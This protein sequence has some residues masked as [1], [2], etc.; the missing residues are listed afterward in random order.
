MRFP[1]KAGNALPTA[2]TL[3]FRLFFAWAVLRSVMLLHPACVSPKTGD[4]T[5]WQSS[6]FI[7]FAW[8]C[9]AVSIPPLCRRTSALH[10]LTAGIALLGTA[11]AAFSIFALYAPAGIYDMFTSGS[12]ATG[13][14][15]SGNSL[16]GFLALCLP[17]TLTLAQLAFI[18]ASLHMRERGWQLLHN[19]RPGDFKLL[20]AVLW[21]FAALLQSIALI[22]SGSRGA[23]IATSAA[24]L[25][26]TAWFILHP[27]SGTRARGPVSAVILT[28]LLVIVIGTGGTYVFSLNRLQDLDDTREVALP[29]TAVWGAALKMIAANPL[30]VGPGG[31]AGAFTPYQPA[32][33]VNSR[34]YH[35]HNDYIELAAE[36]GIP[37]LL[38]FS[39]AMATLIATATCR[40]LRAPWSSANWL[41]RAALI[42]TGAGLIH[43]T[44]DF[45]LSSR[46]GVAALFFCLLG[47]AVSRPEDTAKTGNIPH[48]GN[49]TTPPPTPTSILLASAGMLLLTLNQIRIGVATAL[50]DRS[51]AVIFN[52]P[53]IYF[54][55]P[56]PDMPHALALE[57]LYLA[58]RLTPES[59]RTHFLISH[60]ELHLHDTRGLNAVQ[61][62]ATDYPEI[63]LDFLSTQ[64]AIAMRP[65]EQTAVHAASAAITRA[66]A[67]APQAADVLAQQAFVNARTAA[68]ESS[69]SRAQRIQQTLD[70]AE[71]ARLAAPNDMTVQR[72]LLWA[73]A[74]LATPLAALSDDGET[75]AVQHMARLVG[76]HV[77]HLGH[78]APDDIFHQWTRLG[79]NPADELADEPLTAEAAWHFY[80]LYD[81]QHRID[82]ALTALDSLERSI[83]TGTRA[84]N[85]VQ[86]EPA[87]SLEEIYQPRLT[88]ERAKWFLRLGRFDD[89]RQLAPERKAA[90][91]HEV[92]Q[93]MGQR[94]LRNTASSRLRYLELQHLWQ[95]RGLPPERV[96]EYADL[97][98][99]HG[100]SP[101]GVAAILAPLVLFT[102]SP[103]PDVLPGILERM[104][105]AMQHRMTLME[106]RTALTQGDRHQARTL[107]TGLFHN[108][109]EDP[110]VL[111]FLIEHA[112]ILG[113]S[114]ALVD[115]AVTRL[116]NITPDHRLEMQILGGRIEL[117]GFSV[118]E[119]SIDTFWCFRSAVPSD[120]QLLLSFRNRRSRD[121]I[122]STSV[123]F[124]QA[125]G[126]AFGAG[127]PPLGAVIRLS[128]PWPA[129]AI[130]G[131]DITL[132]LY[133][134]SARQRLPSEEALFAVKIDNWK[135]LIPGKDR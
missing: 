65:D 3:C 31:F 54:W 132:G 57:H 8:A 23:L 42:S 39:L 108:R 71:R 16:G 10:T 67:L 34:V 113:I 51:E 19:A 100:A 111:A 124:A 47:I 103:A 83:L 110:D 1:R 45:N 117:R 102:P 81:R 55:L 18:K 69:G 115:A 52:A 14:F 15:S 68:I 122:A 94:F 7:W 41:R 123:R 86:T 87:Q 48:R 112:V 99:Q 95:T 125:A 53:S 5:Q 88:R 50:R 11:Q 85:H 106:A 89:Y 72:Q 82:A 74:A 114:P 59:S 131:D 26:L 134:P 129:A 20:S 107:I 6:L 56:I 97:G 28:A 44:V 84:I 61:Q 62:A 91:R 77:L 32:G 118:T 130:L 2:A 80:L 98:R 66:A 17:L 27:P 93:R 49:H 22:L 33:F 13:T 116:A 101:A 105:L 76:R 128:T 96:L 133:H 35:A 46:P 21:L 63:P 121:S 38:L 78:H 120:L 64:V 92:D 30:G 43:A 25:C 127:N 109:P 70:L 135:T 9:L 36:T 119:N 4:L 12:R 75:E 58:A 90:L 126:R 37:G 73:L 60:A 104:P 29:R 40:L 24:L 79:I